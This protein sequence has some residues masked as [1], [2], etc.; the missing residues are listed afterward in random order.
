[1][2]RKVAAVLAGL[3]VLGGSVAA[4]Q[5]ASMTLYPP[6]AGVPLERYVEALPAMAWVMVLGSEVLGAFLG[7]LV[8]GWIARDGVRVVSGVI[9]G[10]ALA[11]SI[12]NWISFPHPAWFI[13]TQLVGYP[14]ALV[15]VWRILR[16]EPTT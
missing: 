7:G 3:L 9:V 8:A 2:G 6:P 1:M 14:V 15:L 12:F 10:L 11:G 13:V 5:L 16:R 4:L